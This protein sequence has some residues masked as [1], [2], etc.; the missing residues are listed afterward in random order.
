MRHISRDR[1]LSILIISPSV[2]LIGIFVYGFIAWT[3]VVSFSKWDG[4]QPNYESNGLANYRQLFSQEGGVSARRFSIGLWNPLFFIV[5]FLILCVVLGLLLAILL[6]QKVKGEGVFRTI[7]LFPMALS[8]VVT[9]VVWQWIFAPGTESRLRG[10]NALLHAVGE[11]GRVADVL[12]GD[13]LHARL[14]E[15]VVAAPGEH[16]LEA[17]LGQDREPQRVVLVDP[18]GQ[19]GQEHDGDAGGK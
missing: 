4:V 6:D 18:Q 17:Q 12:R 10:V 13:R 5:F 11:L 19:E 14:E 16:H 1:L 9:G 15:V 8:F 2:V 3:G 7:Y